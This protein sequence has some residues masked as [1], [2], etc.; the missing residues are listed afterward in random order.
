MVLWIRGWIVTYM[1]PY[2]A[3]FSG[4]H[5]LNTVHRMLESNS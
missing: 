4:E 3:I 5:P 2:D 1:G